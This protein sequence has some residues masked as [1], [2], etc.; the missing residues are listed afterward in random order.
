M[1]L[2]QNKGHVIQTWSWINASHCNHTSIRLD[3][4]HVYCA[5]RFLKK[6]IFFY[7]LYF[8]SCWEALSHYLS[9]IHFPTTSQSR[10]RIYGCA[11]CDARGESSPSFSHFLAES[12]LSF[13]LF[14][15]ST[16]LSTQVW[17]TR[18]GQNPREQRRDKDWET[19]S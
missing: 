9:W 8:E 5:E 7:Y 13:L 15:F 12:P 6:Y 4:I 18:L 19:H 11:F 16:I 2:Y 10:P 14:C 1:S 3:Y 17:R